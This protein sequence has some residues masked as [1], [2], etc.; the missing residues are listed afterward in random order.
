MKIA[1]GLA[2]GFPLELTLNPKAKFSIP[3]IQFSDK[4][5][6]RPLAEAL[7]NQKIYITPEEYFNCKFRDIFTIHR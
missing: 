1:L 7:I 3:A 5:K 4:S 6:T 2:H